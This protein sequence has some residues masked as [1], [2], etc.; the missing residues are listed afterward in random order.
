MISLPQLN[1]QTLRKLVIVSVAMFGFGFALI[2]FYQKICEV[3]GVNSV[4]KKDEVVNT[5]VDA[6]RV[7]TIDFDSNLRSS[8]PWSFRP[9]ETSLRVHPGELTTVMYEIRNTSARA[10]TGQAIPSR[11]EEHTSELQSH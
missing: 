10:I 9:L 11:S 3:S 4:M 8:L 7:V 5:Q 1:L 6:A 2:P